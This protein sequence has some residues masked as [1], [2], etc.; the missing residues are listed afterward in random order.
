[1][2]S[3]STLVAKA[4]L[5]QLLYIFPFMGCSAL[6]S[7]SPH[8]R[9][10]ALRPVLYKGAARY[11]MDRPGGPFDMLKNRPLQ[12][13]ACGKIPIALLYKDGRFSA[14][15]ASVIMRWVFGRRHS[16]SRVCPVP[17]A[18]LRIHHQS[19]QGEPGYEQDSV[20]AN[21][22]KIERDHVYIDLSSSTKRRKQAH[23]PHPLA[24]PGPRQAGP[25]RVV[26][27]STTVMTKDHPGIAPQTHSWRRR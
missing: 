8:S 25:I 23:V 4:W 9:F 15:S 19:G 7:L 11:R 10:S 21:T 6:P 16:R 14:I 2:E 22:V 18:L 17:L 26:C 3:W 1:M 20:P 27:I 24:R 13:P 5:K 12:Q